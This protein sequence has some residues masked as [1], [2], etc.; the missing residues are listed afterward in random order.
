MCGHRIKEETW[1]EATGLGRNTGSV[2]TF[3]GLSGEKLGEAG[4]KE[5]A[6]GI[7]PGCEGTW[8]AVEPEPDT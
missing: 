8:G 6:L 3:L 7:S 2:N 5:M 4:G 1:W